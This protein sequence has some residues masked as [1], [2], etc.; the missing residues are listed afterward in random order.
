MYSQH[1]TLLFLV[2]NKCLGS[3]LTNWNPEND[4]VLIHLKDSMTRREIELQE[5]ASKNFL[6]VLKFREISGPSPLEHVKELAL[7]F[8]AQSTN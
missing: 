4:K 3:F 5:F 8:K 6:N 2:M 1:F 7:M